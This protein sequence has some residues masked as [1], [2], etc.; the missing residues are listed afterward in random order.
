VGSQQTGDSYDLKAVT[1]GAASGDTGIANGALLLAFAD[2]VLGD[3]DKRLADARVAIVAAMG[4]AALV[5]SAGVAGFFNAIDRIADSTGTP[6]DDQTIAE[7]EDLRADL[8]INAF[9]ATKRAL[10]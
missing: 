2:A 10:G 3:D 5:D 9:A 8:G 6:L 1:G 4:E 7:T